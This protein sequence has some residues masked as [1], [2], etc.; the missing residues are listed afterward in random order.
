MGRLAFDEKYVFE[1]LKSQI[2]V[3][4]NAS[5]LFADALDLDAKS[6]GTGLTDGFSYLATGV[7]VWQQLPQASCSNP[8]QKPQIKDD[9]LTSS[10]F[11]E[12]AA[13][14]RALANDGIALTRQLSNIVNDWRTEIGNEK[15]NFER[16]GI[17]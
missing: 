9:V 8:I 17:L 2:K 6:A 5:L 14:L 12:N 15:L 1:R 10:Q 11:K 4:Q 7:W 3:Y 13:Y 16:F